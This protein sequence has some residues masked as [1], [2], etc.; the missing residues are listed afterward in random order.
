ME[1]KY[2]LYNTLDYKIFGNIEKN[3]EKLCQN[4]KKCTKNCLFFCIDGINT[5]GSLY[6]SEA[7]TYGANV[8]VLE[9]KLNFD[10]E[11]LIKKYNKTT[12]VFVKDL[13]KSMAVMCAN[14]FD[15]PQKKLKIVF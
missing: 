8:V 12:F 1:L 14:F 9:E 2:I 10:I 3:I 13:R 4:S 6:I 11:N 7:I 5:T 15:N